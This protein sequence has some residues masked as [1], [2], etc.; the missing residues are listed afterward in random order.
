V[1]E[2]DP[3]QHRIARRVLTH[4]GY[5]VEGLDSGARALELLLGAGA[6]GRGRYDLLLLDVS[7]LP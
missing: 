1:V 4:L 3:I 2:D 7:G 5:E 6:S